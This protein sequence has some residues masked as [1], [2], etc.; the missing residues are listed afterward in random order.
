[1]QPKE[2]KKIAL[3]GAGGHCKVVVDIIHALGWTVDRIFDDKRHGETLRGIAIEAPEPYYGPMLITIGD[4][5]ARKKIAEK[6]GS[7]VF[8]TAVHPSAVVSPSATLGD[9]SVIMQGAVVQADTVVGK[10]C[11][12]NTNASVDHDCLLED[13]VHIAPGATVCGT[14]HIGQC[15]WVGAGSVVRQGVTIGR[16]CMIGAGAVVVCDI[17]DGM[18]AYGNPAKIVNKNI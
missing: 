13:F 1:M 14:V 9:G 17:A 10:H 18:M 8:Q 15:T 12:V 4:C 11:I 7:A 6:H 5:K 3:Y 2:T 16:D